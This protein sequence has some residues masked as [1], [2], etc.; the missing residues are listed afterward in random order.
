M[1]CWKGIAPILFDCR[2]KPWF[3]TRLQGIPIP[4]ILAI[5][6][7]LAIPVI[8]VMVLMFWVIDVCNSDLMLNKINKRK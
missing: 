3:E 4:A 8:P 5:L 7:I 2:P 1:C 6:A